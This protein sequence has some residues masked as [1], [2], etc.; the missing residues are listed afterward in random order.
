MKKTL[1]IANWKMNPLTLTEAKSNFELIKKYADGIETVETV[2]CAPFIFLSSLVSGKNIKIGAQDCSSGDFAQGPL[3]GEIS[4]KQLY[5]LG[6]EYVIL[7]H[8]E[9]RR[10]L[11]ESIETVN[12]KIKAALSAKLK[13]IFCIGSQ[14]KKLGKEM[15][16]QLEKGLKGLAKSDLAGLIF[17]YEPIWAISTT[18]DKVTAT[19]KEALAGSLFIRKILGRLFDEE[20]SREARIIYGGSVDSTNIEGFVKEGGMS[21]GLVGAA[22]LNPDEFIRIIKQVALKGES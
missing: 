19:P 7:G 15:K 22:S 17:V 20:T 21:G 5:N 13:V 4:A 11:N 12:K 16:S 1:I 18:K 10:Y 9:R 2:V 6:V 8:S 3:T 14:E